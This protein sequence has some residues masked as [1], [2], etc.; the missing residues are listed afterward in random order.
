MWSFRKRQVSARLAPRTVFLVK[1]DGWLELHKTE[2]SNSGYCV[3]LSENSYVLLLTGGRVI[4]TR[5]I[6]GWLPHLG[7][8]SD[9]QDQFTKFKESLANE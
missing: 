4:G 5:S 7:W 6:S 8:P 1:H 9:S 3:R 2:E